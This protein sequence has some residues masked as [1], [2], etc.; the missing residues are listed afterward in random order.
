LE[1]D[2]AAFRPWEHQQND[3]QHPDAIPG[4][5][6]PNSGLPLIPKPY[7]KAQVVEY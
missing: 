7:T 2:E 3:V 4:P 5:P 1:Q 6:D